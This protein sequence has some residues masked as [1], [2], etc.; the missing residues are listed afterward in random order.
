MISVGNVVTNCDGG[1]NRAEHSTGS[2]ESAA[3]KLR[4]AGW[5]VIGNGPLALAYCPEC[6]EQGKHEKQGG[7]K[8][9]A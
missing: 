3:A 1:C 4:R 9:A 2:P 8:G 6:V 5:T 7:A